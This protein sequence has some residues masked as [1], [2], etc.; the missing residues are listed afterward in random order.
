MAKTLDIAVKVTDAASAPLKNITKHLDGASKAASRASQSFTSLDNS[1]KGNGATALSKDLSKLEQNVKLLRD[2]TNG[3]NKLSK[4]SNKVGNSSNSAA[5]GIKKIADSSKASNKNILEFNRSLF[6]TTAFIG[7]FT[8]LGSHLGDSLNEA[9][10]MDRVTQNFEKAF[11]PQAAFFQAIRNTTDNS[12][13]LMEA[14]RAGIAHSALGVETDMNSMATIVA[15]AGTAAKLAGMDSGEGIKAVTKFM[16]EGS[17]QHLEFLNLI[18]STD[19]SLVLSE[20]LMSRYGGVMGKVINL[21]ERQALMQRLLKKATQDS[22]KGTRDYSDIMSDLG[23]SFNFMKEQASLVLLQAFGPMFDSVTDLFWK[24][25]GFIEEIRTHNK[26][27]MHLI[28]V[29]AGATAAIAATA[30]VVGTFR[31][32]LFA[33][34]SFSAGI[35]LVL[36]LLTGLG[37][38][39]LGVGKKATSFV[40]KIK[41]FGA[42]FKGTYELVS[43]FLNSADNYKKGIGIISS[44][45]ANLLREH[46]LLDFVTN[47]SRALSTA[48]VFIKSFIEG[49][50]FRVNEIINVL[51]NISNTFLKVFGIENT[52]WKRSIL[53]FSKDLGENFGKASVVLLTLLAGLKLLKG[54]KN[55]LGNIPIIGKF[56]RGGDSGTGGPKGTSSDPLYVKSLE[57]VLPNASDVELKPELKPGKLAGLIKAVLTSILTALKA[58]A[59]PLAFAIIAGMITK[60]AVESETGQKIVKGAMNLPGVANPFR[61]NDNNKRGEF[62]VG[63]NQLDSDAQNLPITRDTPADMI[64]RGLRDNNLK[65][66]LGLMEKSV[67]STGSKEHLKQPELIREL[68]DVQNRLSGDK[69]ERFK[70]AFT[71]A[72]QSVSDNGLT[73]TPKEFKEILETTLGSKLELSNSHLQGINDKTKK[74]T[75]PTPKTRNGGC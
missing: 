39:F 64:L 14:M 3:L 32:T 68:Q 72:Q 38:L 7:I 69:Q 4:A 56:F 43:S 23:Q 10:K 16:K 33:L 19:S 52:P 8:K 26:E 61:A 50:K 31:L 42:V 35:P 25:R 5:A 27:I 30:A 15:R 37:L 75:G 70:S 65:D 71:A 40:D 1:L 29:F 67:F 28:K 47:L 24:F 9:S 6:A 45:T 53:D 21:T 57:S 17:L 41:V 74:T 46:G 60:S 18:R 36:G 59:K 73:I 49:F 54:A 20:S 58:I 44:S 2:A 55:I 13:D 11:G 22:L 66:S 34:G 12:I 51:S 62:I 63:K 48:G